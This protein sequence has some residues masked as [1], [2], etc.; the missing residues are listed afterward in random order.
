MINLFYLS[1]NTTGGWVTFTYHLAKSLEAAG[2]D[3]RLFKIG[4]RTENFTRPFGYELAY[5]NVSLEDA[6]TLTC[7]NP[8]AILAAAKNFRDAAATLIENGAKLV[9]HDPTELK[10][11]LAGL[12]IDRPWVIRKEVYKQVPGAIFIR[13]PYVRMPKPDVLPKRAGVIST[14]RIDFD[15]NTYTILEANELGAG[16]KIHGFENRLYTK[17]KIKPRFPDWKQSVSHY[18]RT[19]DAAFNLL[20]GAKAMVDLSDIKGDGGGTQYTF[21]EA[22]D[23]GCV[24]I[25][26]EWW[27]KRG[28][29][30]VDEGARQNCWSV[31]DAKDLYKLCRRMRGGSLAA[32]RDQL[33]AQ[34]E[35]CLV[36]HAPKVIVPQV[37]EWL[38]AR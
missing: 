21:L 31:E 10:A 8:T 38:D 34:G 12:D 17:F 7:E 14:S 32:I 29:D 25:I 20:L 19:S 35:R 2:Q 4:N 24:P 23:A 5:Q 37:M 9:L 26:G 36:R 13:H 18:P 33:A 1:G 11:G 28:D 15:K 16:V 30:M 22:W 6:V 3:Y 27:V